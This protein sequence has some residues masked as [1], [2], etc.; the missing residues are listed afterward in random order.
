MRGDIEAGGAARGAGGKIMAAVNGTI[1]SRAVAAAIA[2]PPHA[3]R[4]LEVGR[5]GR[6]LEDLAVRERDVVGQFLP[7]GRKADGAA[8][9]HV[10]S[11]IDERIEH[12]VEELI[13]ELKAG[14]LRPGRR[15]A[16]KKRQRIGEIGAGEG[17][18]RQERRRERRVVEE[19]ID[20]AG[21][22]LMIRAQACRLLRSTKRSPHVQHHVRLGVTQACRETDG[23]V[24]GLEFC[25][26]A[27]EPVRTQD[28]VALGRIAD[29]WC[30]HRLHGS[31]E[32]CRSSDV[33][34][35][36]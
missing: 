26:S 11:A 25:K 12:D 2:R 33:G 9:I 15:F 8:V 10:A 6:R 36:G 21:D 31:A 7:L 3:P 29:A 4:L 17:E 30:E 5:L 19:I 20:G 32:R 22:G 13:G 23:Q 24:G 1:A 16:R 27:A 34:G 35:A 14:L 28:V 18:Q